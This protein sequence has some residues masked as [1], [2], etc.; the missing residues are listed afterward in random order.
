MLI[1]LNLDNEI[2]TVT[3]SVLLSRYEKGKVGL[4]Y[5]RINLLRGSYRALPR[6]G[7]RTRI[8]QRVVL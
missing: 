3:T 2:P 1:S 5:P 4:V 6:P 8:S 7:I